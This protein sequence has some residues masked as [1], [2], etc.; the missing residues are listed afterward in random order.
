MFG[1]AHADRILCQQASE[2]A[3]KKAAWRDG[4]KARSELRMFIPCEAVGVPALPIYY[5]GDDQGFHCH[6]GT[7]RVNL[8]VVLKR[9]GDTR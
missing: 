7:S 3:T 9:A 6:A 4:R 5:G 8:Q 1:P 2:A